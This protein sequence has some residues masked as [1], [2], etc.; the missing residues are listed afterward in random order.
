MREPVPDR[1]PEAMMGPHLRAYLEWLA[2]SLA[3]GIGV[4]LT[5][6]AVLRL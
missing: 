6:L 1:L 4:G 2:V 5:L 3:L